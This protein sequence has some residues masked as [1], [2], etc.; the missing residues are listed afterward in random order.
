MCLEK[1]FWGQAETKVDFRAGVEQMK[2][3]KP[4]KQEKERKV[5][6]KETSNTKR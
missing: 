2:M 6:T 1:K 3:K 4:R 5:I